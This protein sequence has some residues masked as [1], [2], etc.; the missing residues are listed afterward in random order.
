MHQQPAHAPF[1]PNNFS[2]SAHRSGVSGRIINSS[3]FAPLAGITSLVEKKGH[4]ARTPAH[5]HPMEEGESSA[6]FSAIRARHSRGGSQET[7][8]VRLLFLLPKR[9]ERIRVRIP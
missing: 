3:G 9:W 2:K 5:S 1:L 4:V 7:G 6:S 8:S